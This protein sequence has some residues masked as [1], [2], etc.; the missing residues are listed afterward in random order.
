MK[1]K[2]TWRR[3]AFCIIRRWKIGEQFTSRD[4]YRFENG[5]RHSFPLNS[6]ITD[7]LR[8][9]MQTFR[10]EGFVTFVDDLGTY[11]RTR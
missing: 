4:L 6:H 10:D 9:M 11:A 1:R 5:L 7:K 8:Q 2:T 3:A